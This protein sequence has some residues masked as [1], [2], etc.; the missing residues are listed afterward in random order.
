MRH[1]Y[2]QCTMAKE[3]TP[4]VAEQWGTAHEKYATDRDAARM[5]L[6]NNAVGRQL[7]GRFTSCADGVVWARNNL[8]LIVWK[9]P[10]P[11]RLHFFAEPPPPPP[12]WDQ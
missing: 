1:A 10:P 5:D 8:Q 3:L 2:W 12:M 6:H 9:G 7:A 11:T 4:Y